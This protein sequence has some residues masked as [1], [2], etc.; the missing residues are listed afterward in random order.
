MRLATPEAF[1]RDP[2]EVHA[3]YNARRRNLLT[4]QPNPA[5]VALAKL[6]AGLADRGGALFTC[7]QNIDDL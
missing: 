6:E 3:F 4:A 1:A 2:D 7:T 5:H